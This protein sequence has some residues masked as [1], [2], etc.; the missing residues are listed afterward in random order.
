MF[1]LQAGQFIME[2]TGV[3][4]AAPSWSVGAALVR[5]NLLENH[6]NFR[7]ADIDWRPRQ[8]I[9]SVRPWR[10]FDHSGLR[11]LDQDASCQWFRDSADAC[12]FLRSGPFAGFP[13]FR[14]KGSDGDG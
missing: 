4:V 3:P 8:G 5:F 11:E 6:N 2:R 14:E 7:Q 9:T 1:L 13:A 10:A 12:H